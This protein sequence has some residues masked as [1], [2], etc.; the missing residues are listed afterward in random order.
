MN[1]VVTNGSGWGARWRTWWRPAPVFLTPGP[2]DVSATDRNAWVPSHDQALLAWRD[3]C[4]SHAGWRCQLALSCQWVM[5]G[6][7]REQDAVTPKDARAFI[8]S[9]WQ[10]YVDLG[11]E[12]LAEHWRV[13]MTRVHGAWL[14]CAAPQLLVQDLSAMAKAHGV[15]V[16]RMGPW[17]VDG[18][19]RWV[20]RSVQGGAVTRSSSLTASE[21]GWSIQLTL[22]SG[23]VS[24]VWAEPVVASPS[25]LGVSGTQVIMAHSC[26]SGSACLR[27][28]AI[29]QALVSGR[30]PA[31]LEGA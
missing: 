3:W 14:V 16:T 23:C 10:H 8:A 29:T 2:A 13:R 28:D 24:G 6:V 17:W 7:V 30:D 27:D 19:Q 25:P 18:A 22:E 1:R 9:Q 26:Q 15:V 21:P 5:S 31:W 20:S 11:E 12:Q 4:V